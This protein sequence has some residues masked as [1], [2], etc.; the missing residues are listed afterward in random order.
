MNK[1]FDYALVLFERLKRSEGVFVDIRG[2]AKE[3]GF[4]SAYLEKVAQELKRANLLEAKKGTGGGYRIARG[5]AGVSVE[6]LINFY[7]P[8]SSFCPLLRTTKSIATSD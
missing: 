3:L 7:H 2:I 4:P 8:M 1:R 5:Q 6:T